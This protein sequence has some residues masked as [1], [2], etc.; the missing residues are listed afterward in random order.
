MCFF[1]GGKR[2]A[3]VNFGWGCRV[4]RNVPIAVMSRAGHTPPLPRGDLFV[5]IFRDNM[6]FSA[7]L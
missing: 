3:V 6:V 5:A 1:A 2:G 4:T 7:G